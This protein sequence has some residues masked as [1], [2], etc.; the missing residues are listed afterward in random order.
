MS[1]PNF[2]NKHEE[3]SLITP[4]ELLKYKKKFG[5]YPEFNP[6]K[7]VIF[8]Y[9]KRLL[10]YV[11]KNHR[12][13][14][15]KGFYGE[16]Y[17]LEETKDQIALIGKFGIG[18]PAVV[19][20]ME[21]LIAFGVR[22]FL[23]IGETGSLRKDLKVGSIVV[24]DKAIREEGTSY[25]YLKPSKYAYASKSMIQTIEETLK[26]FGL[27][28]DVGTTWT[29]DAFYRETVAEVK[30]YQNEGVLTVDMEASAIFALAEYRNVEAGAIFTISD[31][32]AELE[33]QPKFHL[34]RE[35][36]ETLFKVAKKVLLSS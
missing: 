23:S 36:L 19:L 14:K 20:L 30:K 15:V 35:Y 17:L 18:A 7:G 25:H 2:K 3:E 33:W 21:E 31:Y 4:Q 24:C 27:K 10:N 9:S 8:C 12:I 32:L 6:P 29:I 16:T 5:N 28:Y 34:I 1:F 26:K 22:K 13:R 11:I